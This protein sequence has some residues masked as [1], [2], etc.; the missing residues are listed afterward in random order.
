MDTTIVLSAI[1]LATVLALFFLPLVIHLGHRFNLLD[2]PVG[3]KR[4]KNPVPYTG[5][6]ALFVVIWLTIAVASL[7]FDDAFG[8]YSKQL[9]W[10]FLASALICVGG[11]LDDRYHLNE[12]KKLG[13]QIIA[14]LILVTGGLKAPLLSVPSGSLELG[15]FAYPLTIVWVV[16]LTNAINIIDGLDGLAGGV[17]L[18]AAGF[19]LV[20]G[21]HHDV[22][23]MLILVCA[24]IGFLAIFWWY[25]K[26]PAKIFLGDSGSMQIGFLFAVISLGH[27]L[28][29]YTASALYLPML[30]LG[31]PILEIV[32]SS[33][34]RV[35][36]GKSP[37]KADRRHL[38][39]YLALAG[40]NPRQV[41]AVF[42]SLG[43]VF[44]GVSL[45]MLYWNR[46]ILLGILVL[47]MF[48]VF[49]VF[50]VLISTTLPRRRT[51][52]SPHRISGS[53]RTGRK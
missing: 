34:R 10:V 31:V 19:M 6:L 22:G 16:M 42:Y 39:H 8:I 49:A 20:I 52:S 13:I 17:S 48:V 37:L 33:I 50:F 3:H 29:S 45:A 11:F 18:I 43:L 26:Y 9:P 7:L 14:A 38:F 12:W 32:S 53:R 35:S 15:W 21:S 5:G 51:D 46:L 47:F 27:P 41:V 36:A 24:L 30:A 28:K 2:L 40:L 4:H 1:A 25:N 23:A 44:G